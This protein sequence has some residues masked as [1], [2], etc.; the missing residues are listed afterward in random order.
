MFIEAGPA[1]D[2]VELAL[3]STRLRV[4]DHLGVFYR[5]ADER[6][7]VVLPVIEEALAAGCG[8]IYVCDHETPD[9]VRKQLV[10][11][12]IDA[13]G[14]IERGQLRLVAS[15]EVYLAGGTFVPE[16]TVAFYRGAWEASRRDG[17]PILCVLG[18]MSWR[19]RDCPG[20]D[21]FLEYEALYAVHFGD[22]S[23]IT[24][25]LYDVENTRGNQIFDLLRLHGRVLLNGIEM[26]NPCRMDPGAFLAPATPSR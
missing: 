1:D 26:H 13:D 10:G 21:R 8:V 12:G 16:R 15:T 9:T 2:D 17:Y 11:E 14:A 24:L 23:A 7:A 3:E 6:D 4:G 22:A 5:G 20:S 18:E 19:L 25:C